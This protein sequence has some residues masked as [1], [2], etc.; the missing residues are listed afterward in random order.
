MNIIVFVMDQLS[1]LALDL[2]GGP[3]H[4]P[5]ISSLAGNGVLVEDAY[6]NYPLC[7]PSRASLWTGQYPHR[8]RVWSNGR[9]WPITPIIGIA[10]TRPITM[11]NWVRSNGSKSG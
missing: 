11:K 9:K 6:C 1:A 2:Y 10:S 5:A 4:A 7:Q 3:F 8:N